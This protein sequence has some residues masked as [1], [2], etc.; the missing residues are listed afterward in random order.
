MAEAAWQWLTSHLSE[1]SLWLAT[2]GVHTG[3]FVTFTG[4]FWIIQRFNLLHQYRIQKKSPPNDLAKEALREVIIKHLIVGPLSFWLLTPVAR[5]TQIIDKTNP[6]MTPN[7]IF[8]SVTE[9]FAQ[10]FFFILIQDT[11]FYWG[12][13][14]LHTS[15]LYKLIHKKHHRFHQN[16]GIASEFANPV[17]DTINTIALIAGPFLMGTHLVTLWIWFFI[18][19]WET[20]DAHSGYALPFPL[21]PFALFDVAKRHDFHHSQNRGCYGSFFGI[22]DILLGTDKEFK[23]FEQAKK[24]KQIK[25]EDEQKDNDPTGRGKKRKNVEDKTD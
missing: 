24:E 2:A 7:A 17:E 5:L 16:I 18:R 14:A 23:I 22:W 10:I 8:P 21:S 4:F 6:K 11:I 1:S 20:V 3:T 13:R 25:G 9:I 12:H 15:F 19:I